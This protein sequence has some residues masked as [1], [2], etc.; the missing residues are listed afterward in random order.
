MIT[1]LRPNLTALLA[2][3]LAAATGSADVM[4]RRPSRMPRCTHDRYQ[5][6]NPG[7]YP[8]LEDEDYEGFRKDDQMRTREPAEILAS[9]DSTAIKLPACNPFQAPLIFCGYMQPQERKIQVD[10]VL[11]YTA[12]YISTDGEP[13]YTSPKPTLELSRDLTNA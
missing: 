13:T 1:G 3:V 11:R 10:T 4:A 6:R 12:P 5:H 2:L 9:I 8:Y 7:A